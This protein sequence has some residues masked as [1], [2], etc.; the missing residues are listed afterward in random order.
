MSQGFFAATVESKTQ[1]WSFP[2]LVS[3]QAGAGQLRYNTFHGPYI[4]LEKLLRLEC[5]PI[6]LAQQIAGKVESVWMPTHVAVSGADYKDVLYRSGQCKDIRKDKC[7][8]PNK[9]NQWT[10]GPW[11]TQIEIIEKA[12]PSFLFLN[13]AANHVHCATLSTKLECLDEEKFKEHFW[14]TVR[15]VKAISSIKGG[16][17][18]TV[19]DVTAI[20]LLE[21]YE[22]PEGRPEYSGLKPI[23]QQGVDHPDYVLDAEEIKVIRAFVDMMNQEIRL[24]AQELNFAV[25]PVYQRFNEIVAGKVRLVSKSGYS[26][27]LIHANW[28]TEGKPGILGLDGIHPN[29][30]GHTLMANLIIQAVNQTYQIDIEEIDE[31]AAWYFDSLNQTP[32]D[33]HQVVNGWGVKTVI[34]W[35]INLIRPGKNR[36]GRGYE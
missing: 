35:L 31:Y 26:P 28:P 4:N 10:L 8:E 1:E 19:P 22:D 5:G 18:F 29:K 32:I 11:G 16:A 27:G 23:L 6:C 34:N 36:K 17:F 14:E 33:L 9:Y 20:R 12:R 2:V 30:L 21:Y 7:K 25:A 13:A 3:K 24:A 15:R